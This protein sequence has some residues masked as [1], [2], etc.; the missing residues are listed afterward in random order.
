MPA[1]RSA[2][3]A[4]QVL[5]G[6]GF[7][8][9]SGCDREKARVPVCRSV[10]PHPPMAQER[11]EQRPDGLVRIAL[12]KAYTDGTVAV[13]MDPLSLLRR[14]VLGDEDDGQGRWVPQTA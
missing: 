5:S 3:G 7:G 2:H 6:Q 11:L 13:D 10:V 1:S 8:A 9:L 4:H 14:Q 12:K